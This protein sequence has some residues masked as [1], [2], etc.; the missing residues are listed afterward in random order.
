MIQVS[1]DVISLIQANA[2]LVHKVQT[3]KEI[4]LNF[5]IPES[6]VYEFDK[7]DALAK[8]YG[9]LPDPM[10]P[11]VF[12][13]KLANVCIT[14][15]EHP[16]IRYQAS[17]NYAREVAM[18]LQQTLME[19]KRLNPAYW[20]HGDDIH[21]DRERGQILILDRT[22]DPLSP[23]MHE[24]TYQAMVYDLLP[25]R[26]GVISYT[27]RTNKGDELKKEALLNENDDL[28][29]E[30]R[31]NHIAKVIE[32]I[33]DRMKDIIQNN[34]GAALARKDGSDV[35]ITTMAAAV[36][37]LP[38]YQQ[39][40]SRLGEHVAIS[41]Q[42]MD[43][44]STAGLLQFSQVEQTVSTGVDE[45][46]KEVKG[47]KLIELVTDALRKR[48]LATE[49]KIRLLAIFMI[50]QRGATSEE[51][52][53]VIQ[54]AGLSGDE[55]QVLLNFDRIVTAAQGGSA[56][57]RGG[58]AA[59]KTGFFSSIFRRTPVK[60]AATPEGEYT[61]TR[62]VPQLRVLVEQL[63]QG[64]LPTDKFPSHGPPMPSKDAKP[65]AKS[66]RKFGANSRWTNNKSD[67]QYDGG[68]FMVF[69][70]GGMS[71]AETRA[72]YEL[73]S[74]HKKEVIMGSTSLM[75]PGQYMKTVAMLDSALTTSGEKAYSM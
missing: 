69:V 71:Y 41:Q 19:Y 38:E 67:V 15:N 25:V 11:S 35:T 74:Q 50:S 33:K 40:M 70:A 12:G 64:E 46:G 45:D 51:R 59:P 23:L 58:E 26:E 52:R 36:K 73:M 14:L 9:S 63:I 28:W 53:Q 10:L 7:P 17:S 21:H 18:S 61:D 6:F 32:T 5:L 62:H 39:T 75:S 22:F 65:V 1:P 43:A 42:C 29:I 47:A 13:R 4:Y 30:L 54:A 8:L 44:F 3:F 37:E 48:S 72:G 66:V 20:V 56:A 49:M 27:T 24:Y 2:T 16:N 60:H 31:H 57:S 34:A 55:Q 68:R